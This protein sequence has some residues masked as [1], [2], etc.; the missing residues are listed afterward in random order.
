MLLAPAKS[1]LQAPWNMVPARIA[2]SWKIL[3]NAA[4]TYP[5]KQ[6]HMTALFLARIKLFLARRD[7]ISR[8]R[9]WIVP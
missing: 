8:P 7:V 2:G 1:G 6:C 4:M 3:L 9:I 5:V